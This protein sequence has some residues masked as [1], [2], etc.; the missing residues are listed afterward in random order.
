MFS[1]VLWGTLACSWLR[2]LNADGFSF[3]GR[4]G[5]TVPVSVQE[6]GCPQVV[7]RLV[8]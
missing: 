3:S 5:M 8:V 2:F 6:W 1:S 4:K 7:D